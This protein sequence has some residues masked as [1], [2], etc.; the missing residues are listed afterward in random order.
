VTEDSSISDVHMVVARDTS[1]GLDTEGIVFKGMNVSGVSTM[2][3][4]EVVEVVCSVR[5][6]A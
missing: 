5:P 2:P 6:R 1:L 3:W 4:N